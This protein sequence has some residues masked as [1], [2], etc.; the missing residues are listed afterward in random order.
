MIK[1][2][3]GLITIHNA[4]NYGAIMQAYATQET[5]KE[6]G[7]VEV[8]NFDNRHVSNSLDIVRFKPSIHGILGMG[9][10]ILRLIPRI[11]AVKK[12]KTFISE[13]FNLLP[14]HTV[15]SSYEHF[16]FVVSGSDQIWNPACVTSDNSFIEEYFL[17]I[18]CGS[19]VK[20]AYASSMGAY[21]FNDE[22]KIKLNELWSTYEHLSCRE[23]KGTRLIKSV[24]GKNATHVLDPTL[25][26]SRDSWL[27]KFDVSDVKHNEPYILLYFIK[28]S[29]LFKEVVREVKKK[30]NCKV[31][32]LNQSLTSGVDSDLHIRDAGPKDFIELFHNAKFVVTDSFHG[33]TFSL[34]F[35][36]NF[37]AVS[38]GKNVNRIESLLSKVGLEKQIVST[39]ID[40]EK[41]NYEI[42]YKEPIK[43]L[44]KEINNSLSYL[45]N[46]FSD[47]AK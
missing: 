40:L 18:R 5:L 25:L 38:P 28:K 12:F 11:K 26:I 8:I 29:P 13:R 33:T 31:V 2:K 47:E 4:N 7:D 30:F 46:A 43:L 39:D 36:K 37:I 34:K 22:E 23:E 9:K 42:D 35:N 1:K 44:N 16:D 6:F 17:N 24:T 15:D 14:P 27:N 45:K 19:A 21:E 20:I 32:V 3:I 10:D 41:I